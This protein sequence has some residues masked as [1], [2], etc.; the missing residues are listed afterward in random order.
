MSNWKKK[1][2]QEM[3][4]EMDEILALDE[5]LT[6]TESL[7]PIVSALE[8]EELSL[9]WR[10][11]LNEKLAAVRPKTRRRLAL[12]I[13]VGASALAAATL[14]VLFFTS[15]A[16]IEP[17]PAIAHSDTS[18][19]ALIIRSHREA[20]AATVLGVASPAPARNASTQVFDWSK[21]EQS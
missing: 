5:A 19:E 17:A 12:W 10:S 1:A 18:V 21:L 2:N 16:T 9:A 20:E 7:R 6:G 8:S 4:M 15:P 3:P 13:P 14:A 11:E